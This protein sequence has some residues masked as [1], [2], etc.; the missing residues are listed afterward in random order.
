MQDCVLFD[1]IVTA[2]GRRFGHA[3]LNSAATLNALSLD[4]IDRL[5][6][7]FR[8]GRRPEHRRRRTRLSWRQVRSARAAT[9]SCCTRRCA[10]RRRADSATSSTLLRARVSARLS[11][12]HLPQAD[13]LLGP[14][15]RNGRR[16]RPVGGSV[17]PRGHAADAVGN[18]GNLRSASTRM[19]AVA[20]SFAA[21][22][23]RAACSWRSTGASLTQLRRAFRRLGRFC[24]PA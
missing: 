4:M 21:R 7:S 8:S 15:H 12:P 3:T 5:G 24:A 6:P 2:C 19:W 18:A 17:P 1:E 22:R 10:K 23:E 11:D 13:P 20:G 9:C 16:Y 14:W